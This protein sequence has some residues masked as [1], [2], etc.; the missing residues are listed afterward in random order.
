MAA[1]LRVS[2]GILILSLPGCCNCMYVKKCDLRL[3]NRDEAHGDL[4]EIKQMERRNI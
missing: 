3:Q 1:L 2:G 4:H